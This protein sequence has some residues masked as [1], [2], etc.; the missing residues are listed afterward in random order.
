MCP[1]KSNTG[2]QNVQGSKTQTFIRGMTGQVFQKLNICINEG[3]ERK[4]TDPSSDQTKVVTVE[5]GSVIW[6][7]L[8]EYHPEQHL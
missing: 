4:K 1:L 3:R 6:L 7:I 5:S 2:M 8:L